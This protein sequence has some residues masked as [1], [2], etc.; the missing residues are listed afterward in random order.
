VSTPELP[1]YVNAAGVGEYLGVGR[2]AVGNWLTR[3]PETIPKPTAWV[4]DNRAK[5]D[6]RA[7]LWNE[8]QLEAWKRWFLQ[9]GSVPAIRARGLCHPCHDDEQ[10]G[11]SRLDT[12][13]EQE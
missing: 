1:T 7:P 12:M 13:P 10:R 6:Q 4:R 3:H 9:G 8:D 5:K 11:K 2:A